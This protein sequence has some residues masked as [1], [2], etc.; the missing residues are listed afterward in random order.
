MTGVNFNDFK[1]KFGN[2]AVFYPCTYFKISGEETKDLSE[3]FNEKE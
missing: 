2:D 1:K 3:N